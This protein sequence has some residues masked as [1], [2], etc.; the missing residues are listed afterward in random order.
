MAISVLKIM[1]D[2]IYS[3]DIY[4]YF[5]DKYPAIFKDLKT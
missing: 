1:L 5:F 4:F 3:T 2:C